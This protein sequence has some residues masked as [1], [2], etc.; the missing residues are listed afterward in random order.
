[1]LFARSQRTLHADQIQEAIREGAIGFLKGVG[2]R[3]VE[4]MRG[5]SLMLLRIQEAIAKLLVSYEHKLLG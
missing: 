4:V 1:M 5:R 3:S 2:K